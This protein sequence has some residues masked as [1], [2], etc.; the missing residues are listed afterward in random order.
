MSNLYLEAKFNNNTDMA[1]KMWK[2]CEAKLDLLKFNYFSEQVA[3]IAE[4]DNHSPAT[5]GI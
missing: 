1:N 2:D 3:D 4:D 5:I